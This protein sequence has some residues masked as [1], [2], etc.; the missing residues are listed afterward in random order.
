MATDL[1]PE[2]SPFYV[3]FWLPAGKDA[4]GFKGW[5]D[6]PL[7]YSSQYYGDVYSP[8]ALHIASRLNAG[9]LVDKSILEFT[10]EKLSFGDSEFGMRKIGGPFKYRPRGRSGAPADPISG[11]F[12]LFSSGLYSFRL[13]IPVN[14]ALGGALETAPRT[15][16]N[17]KTEGTQTGYA[18]EFGE[19]FFNDVLHPLLDLKWRKNFAY[20]DKS[21]HLVITQ[22]PSPAVAGAPETER[23]PYKGILTYYQLDLLYNGIFDAEAV[24][25]GIFGP[26]SPEL[27]AQQRKVIDE[28]FALE[29]IIRSFTLLSWGRSKRQYILLGSDRKNYSL[30]DPEGENANNYFKPE[31]FLRPEERSKELALKEHLFHARLTY[32][33]MEQFMRVAVTFGLSSYREGLGCAR[34]TILLS[35]MRAMENIEPHQLYL[36]TKIK[37]SDAKFIAS[38]GDTGGDSQHRRGLLERFAG[39]EERAHEAEDGYTYSPITFT[40]SF[41][42]IYYELM[43]SKLPALSFLHSLLNDMSQAVTPDEARKDAGDEHYS[44]ELNYSRKTF[45]G[46]L[47]QFK[48]KCDIIEYETD[49][50]RHLMERSGDRQILNELTDTR[51]IHELNAEDRIKVE[52]SPEQWNRLSIGIGYTQIGVAFAFGFLGLATWAADKVYDADIDKITGTLNKIYKVLA[53]IDSGP[54]LYILIFLAIVQ[55]FVI[56]IRMPGTVVRAI[57]SG[58]IP[59]ILLAAL[60]IYAIASLRNDWPGWDPNKFT[61]DQIDTTRA[62]MTLLV[63]VSGFFFAYSSWV[64]FKAMSLRHQSEK[65]AEPVAKGD[66]LSTSIYDFAGLRQVIDRE[67]SAKLF[68]RLKGEAVMPSLFERQLSKCRVF[69]LLSEMPSVGVERRKYSFGSPAASSSRGI[70][71]LRALRRWWGGRPS[72]LPGENYTLHVEIELPHPSGDAFLTDMRIA[73]RTMQMGR[74]FEDIDSEVKHLVYYYCSK[75]L[76]SASQRQFES[77]LERHFAFKDSELKNAAKEPQRLPKD[78]KR[79]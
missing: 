59:L 79:I 48:R 26:G 71:P 6:A 17:R 41:A 44:V 4:F 7:C 11:T 62:E 39:R 63:I 35:N 78:W 45:K 61:R 60:F 51:K 57:S 68:E 77:I 27:A 25:Q 34:K 65:S 29:N 2:T 21:G 22:K 8:I 46:A 16:P 37:N 28:K 33:A 23:C 67:K 50:V 9:E 32:S 72:L 10:G 42:E 13:D 54:M 36:E 18:K 20:T 70:R 56:A 47:N 58:S 74:R 64:L 43:K 19:A 40:L 24:P 31:V 53:L 55:A 52:I 30:R 66:E 76:E 69:N 3:Y 73:V 38:G 49:S 1:V 12:T 14:S 15:N 75:I 5:E